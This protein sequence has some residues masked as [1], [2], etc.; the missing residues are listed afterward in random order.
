[1]DYEP[2]LAE[3]RLEK[4]RHDQSLGS[5]SQL[6]IAIVVVAVLI[7]WYAAQAHLPITIA[8][9]M[10][11]PAYFLLRRTEKL[12]RRSNQ[13]RRLIAFYERI[14]TRQDDTWKDDPESG[15]EYADETH[16]YSPDLDLFGRGS[17]FQFMCLTRTGVGRDKLAH[18]MTELAAEPEATARAAAVAELRD[19]TDLREAIAIA[20]HGSVSDCRTE[21]F[22]KWLRA[23]SQQIPIWAGPV[24][25]IL[26]LGVPVI[27]VL[28]LKHVIPTDSLIQTLLLWAGIA[29]AFAMLFRDRVAAIIVDI[30]MPSIDLAIL[31]DLIASLEEQKFTSP[32]LRTLADALIRQGSPA[33]RQIAR[34]RRKVKILETG[35]KWF[36]PLTWMLLWDTQFAIAIERWRQQHGGEM[37]VWLDAIGEFEVLNTIAAYAFDHPNDATAEFV[38]GPALFEATGLGHPLLDPEKCVRNDVHLSA[39][40][41]LWIVSGSNMSGKST[42]LRS[43]GL[44]VLLASMGAPVRAKGLRLSNLTLAASIRLHDSLL[45]GKSKFFVEVERLKNIIDLASGGRS[46]LFLV[47]ELLS[48]TNSQDR[49]IAAEAVI[50]ELLDRGA[51]GLLTTHDLALTKIADETHGRNVHL[52]DSSDA[53]G[54]NFDYTLRPGVVQQSNALAIVQLL[55]IRLNGNR[56]G[57]DQPKLRAPSQ[58]A[59]A[60]GTPR[61]GPY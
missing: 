46:L 57:A 44:A 17:L 59:A 41:A 20:G 16:L 8:F 60:A 54:L 14:R 21:T 7:V 24:A 56:E 34:L 50:H 19:R 11:I 38:D 22:A 10:I 47:D 13:F 3:L 33:S 49:K 27:G 36:E 4:T 37:Q 40:A 35:K 51:I 25:A 15:E 29:A 26:S 48:G 12:Q 2:R 55:G 58:T 42:L 30:G 43:C 23:P 45:D 53:G 1:M 6:L 61:D 9:V 18:Y 39:G 5:V 31:A 28:A 52:A 32:K